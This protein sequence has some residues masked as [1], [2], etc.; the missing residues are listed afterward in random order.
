MSLPAE[1]LYIIRYH[2]LYPWHEAG[3]YE[4]L[5]SEYDKAMKGWVKLFNRH[6]LY[7]KRDE[8]FTESEVEALRAYYTRL[9][10]KYM[11]A[12]LEW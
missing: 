8:P 9:I 6:D 1:A 4:E 3:C 10:E 2:S 11:P 12:E 7:T 5:E